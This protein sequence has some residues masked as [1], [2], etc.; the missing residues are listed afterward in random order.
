MSSVKLEYRER[1]KHLMEKGRQ[2]TK[3]Q[4][5]QKAKNKNKNKKTPQNQL[6]LFCSFIA[7]YFQYSIF[8]VE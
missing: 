4:Q 6:N 2:E 7:Y 5:Q 8:P 1:I 3:K